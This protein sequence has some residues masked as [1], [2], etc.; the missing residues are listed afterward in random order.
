MEYRLQAIHS[1]WKKGGE[2]QEE[3]VQYLQVKVTRRFTL[4]GLLEKH[5][6][7]TLDS[8]IVPQHVWLQKS[9]FGDELTGWKHKFSNIITN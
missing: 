8:E 3:R 9:V 7:K 2:F 5:Y 6:W 1:K 4:F